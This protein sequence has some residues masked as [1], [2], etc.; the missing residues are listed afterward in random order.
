MKVDF[1]NLDT[2]E[3]LFKVIQLATKQAPFGSGKVLDF[4]IESV[5]FPK[6]SVDESEALWDKIEKNVTKMVEKKGR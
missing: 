6:A 3:L 2:D 1:D 5:F 4:V